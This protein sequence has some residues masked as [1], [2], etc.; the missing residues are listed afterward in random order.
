[1]PRGYK[2]ALKS[3]RASKAQKMRQ[4]RDSNELIYKVLYIPDDEKDADR[5]WKS[6][7][8]SE[9]Y[10]YDL[11]SM[12]T[13]FNARDPAYRRKFVSRTKIYADTQLERFFPDEKKWMAEKKS[14]QK[15]ISNNETFVS[16]NAAAIASEAATFRSTN[17]VVYAVGT[18]YYRTTAEAEA[19]DPNYYPHFSD[20]LTDEQIVTEFDLL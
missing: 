14:E 10:F 8:A 13:F 9:A 2:A 12:N 5:M 17:P 15:L 16:K 18:D 7:L 19:V 1:M 6:G 4:F 20:S 3:A 11:S